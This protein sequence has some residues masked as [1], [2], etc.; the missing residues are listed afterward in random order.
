MIGKPVNVLRRFTRDLRGA[1]AVEFALIAPLMLTMFFGTVELAS[2]VAVDRKVTLV[3]R[4]LS[5]LVAQATAVN[6]ADLTN[7]FNAAAAIVTPYAASPLTAKISAV[8]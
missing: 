4:A 5:D 6:D 8:S 1:A 2:G 3:S 7:V